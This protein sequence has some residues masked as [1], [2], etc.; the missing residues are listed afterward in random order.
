MQRKL[1]TKKQLSSEQ[2]K[3][4][5]DKE[6]CRYLKYSDCIFEY[7]T[8][9]NSIYIYANSVDAF[10]IIMKNAPLS[11]FFYLNGSVILH[12]SS[13]VFNNRI[14]AFIA[15]KGTG[16]S[17]LAYSLSKRYKLFSDDQLK[18]TSIKTPAN[19]QC[20][21][22]CYSPGTTV[23]LTKETSVLLG[24]KLQGEYNNRY[25]KMILCDRSMFLQTPLPIGAIFVLRRDN[26][27]DTPNV[28]PIKDSFH[29]KIIIK[30]HILGKEAISNNQLDNQ[31]LIDL[32]SSSIGIYYLHLPTLSNS[33]NTERLIE[34]YTDILKF[35][36]GEHNEDN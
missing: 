32:L 28:T 6:D 27:T 11:F 17:T 30:N 22:T 10:R 34:K 24:E 20:L 3:E 25:D 36:L 7:P 2:I 29:K 23:K 15:N 33:T 13:V 19:Q 18:I 35:Y 9:D 4:F 31:T 21:L 1:L 26:A 8:N 14:A 16:K 5:V 12:S